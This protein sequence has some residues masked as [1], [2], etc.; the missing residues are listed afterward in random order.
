MNAGTRVKVDGEF[1]ATVVEWA[2]GADGFCPDC[3]S[4]KHIPVQ[5]DIDRDTC[6]IETYPAERLTLAE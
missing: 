1:P 5:L 3:Q 6:G 2:Q 4:G